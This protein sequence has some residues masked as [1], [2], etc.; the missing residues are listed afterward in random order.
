MSS[1][2]QTAC[3]ICENELNEADD[4]VTT[5][6]SHTFHYGC[7]QDRLEKRGRADCHVCRQDSALGN[8]LS[9]KNK[10]KRGECSICEDS[11]NWKDDIITTNCNHTFHRICAQDRLD[12]RGRTDCHVCHQESA[13]ENKLS[14]NTATTIK[15]PTEESLKQT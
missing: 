15:K 3:S 11:W 4:L 1:L 7:A 14:R 6:C 12:K 13:I 10:I 5:D 2:T 8:A 9:L